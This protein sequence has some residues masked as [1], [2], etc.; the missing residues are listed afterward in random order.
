M[1]KN[2]SVNSTSD[3]KKTSSG[4]LAD[5][6]EGVLVFFL[7]GGATGCTGSSAPCRGNEL[8]LVL[9][10][11][12][13]SW[14]WPKVSTRL[15]FSL[16]P[17]MTTSSGMDLLCCLSM[18]R[19]C[20]LSSALFGHNA[21]PDSVWC[22]RSILGAELQGFITTATPTFRPGRPT[23]SGRL[24]TGPDCNM[25]AAAVLPTTVRST[26]LRTTSSFWWL[27]S[28]SAIFCL[29][30]YIQRCLLGY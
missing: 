2:T 30:T 28:S 20:R 11:M 29:Q 15:I 13:G 4:A 7:R 3:M 9:W 21:R 18:P 16:L 6:G 24:P 12:S 26:V 1:N 8:D 17:E 27:S 25:Q 22:R 19:F 10:T 14:G 23:Q 5:D